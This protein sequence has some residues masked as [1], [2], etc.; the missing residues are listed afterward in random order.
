M[1][2]NRI[3]EISCNKNLFDKAAPDYNNARKNSALTENVTYISN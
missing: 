1:I 2:S 3:S